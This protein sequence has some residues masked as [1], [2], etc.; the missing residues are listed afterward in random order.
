V[1]DF[2]PRAAALVRRRNGGPIDHEAIIRM[3]LLDNER[4]HVGDA[5]YGFRKL[6]DIAERSI[7]SSPY[8]DPATSVQAIDRLHD[9]LRQLALRRIPDGEHRDADG[10]LRLVTRELTWDGYVT[11]A[12][13]EVVGVGSSSP[14][15]SRRLLAALDDLLAVAP[16]ERRP[17]L[18]AQRRR[19]LTE[20]GE[21]GITA[22]PD[23]QGLGSGPDLTGAPQRGPLGDH[24]AADGAAGT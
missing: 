14:L 21:A 19:L 24:P 11:L 9:G 3:V 7:A 23:V 4:T 1:G 20:A 12:F 22:V 13:E 16:A 6:V 2:V 8:N 18:E 17:P 15:V 10:A 5:A